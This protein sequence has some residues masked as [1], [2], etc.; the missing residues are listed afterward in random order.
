MSPLTIPLH[1][2]L[3]F[4]IVLARVGGMVTFA[5]FWAHKAIPVQIR[6]VLAM[7][8]SLALTPI[9]ATRLPTPPSDLLPLG[10]M[11][12][13]ELLVG[14]AFGFV[15][16]LVFSGIEIAAHVIGFQMGFSLAGTIDPSTTAQT[17]A[18]GVL[19]QM[20]ALVVLMAND[21]HHW[22]L[23]ATMRSFHEVP[24]GTAHISAGVAQ[25]FL[26][27]SADALAVGIA[28]AAPA[29][30]ML[31]AVEVALAIAGRAIPQIQVMVLGFPIKIA[32]GLWLI[33]G[34][35]YFMPAAV[36]STLATMQTA[37]N[38]LMTTL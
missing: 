11:I 25:L 34:S 8:L 10:L 35:L 16:R 5:P 4:I 30:V 19:G 7:I 1:P 6:I 13:L 22:F 14:M 37:L 36:R 33:G 17:A 23:L 18:L 26:R 20:L 12:V 28:L 24:M 29:I 31:L 32:A 27:M 15:G 2:L 9:L 3:I 38:R 21:G